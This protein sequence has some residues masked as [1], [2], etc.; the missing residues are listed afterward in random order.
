MHDAEDDM[1][2]ER[3]AGRRCDGSIVKKVERLD[4]IIEDLLIGLFAACE[5]LD[6]LADAG[7]QEE[8]F[9]LRPS[10]RK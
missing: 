9:P 2:L 6:E 3:R 10:V 7:D 1:E 4:E 5:S 8:R